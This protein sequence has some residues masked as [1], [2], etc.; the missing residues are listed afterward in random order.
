MGIK[1]SWSRV[2]DHDSYG[3]N[4]DDIFKAR[5]GKNAKPTQ[6]HKDKKKEQKKN[7]YPD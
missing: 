7:G 5:K 2:K 1:G 3:K 4:F 6:P